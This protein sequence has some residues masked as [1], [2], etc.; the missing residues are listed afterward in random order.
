MQSELKHQREHRGNEGRN[1]GGAGEGSETRTRVEEVR[2]GAGDEFRTHVEEV[3]CGARD[4][5]QTYVE[6][7][8]CGDDFQGRPSLRKQSSEGV[9]LG[10]AHSQ[11]LEERNRG[12][13][14]LPRFISKHSIPPVHSH[15]SGNWHSRAADQPTCISLT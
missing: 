7:V 9:K 10:C 4:E 6:E 3:G 13:C 2:C 15:Q 11:R 8:G 1:R 12:P 14:R 5:F